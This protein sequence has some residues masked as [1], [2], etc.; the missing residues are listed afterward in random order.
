LV[1]KTVDAT[2]LFCPGPI[3]ILKG[4]IKR[5]DKGDIVELLADDSDTPAQAQEYCIEE[6]HTLNSVEEKDGVFHI[7]V[8][9]NT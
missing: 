2:G 9:K 1:T 7:K 5:V 4:I 3:Q 6:G 8:I